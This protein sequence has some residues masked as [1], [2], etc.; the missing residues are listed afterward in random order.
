MRQNNKKILELAKAYPS[1]SQIWGSVQNQGKETT[2]SM[3]ILFLSSRDYRK[4]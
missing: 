2:G 4:Q 1:W 3:L